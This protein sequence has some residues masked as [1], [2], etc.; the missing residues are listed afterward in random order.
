MNTCVLLRVSASIFVR[1]LSTLLTFWKCGYQ[2]LAIL[3]LGKLAY[4]ESEPWHLNK[5]YD[6]NDLPDHFFYQAA[7]I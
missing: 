2:L 1:I 6:A 4:I 7:D 5:F 3:L